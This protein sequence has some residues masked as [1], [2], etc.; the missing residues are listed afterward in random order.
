MPACAV[1]ILRVVFH[2]DEH[3]SICPAGLRENSILAASGGAHL[4]VVAEARGSPASPCVAIAAVQHGLVGEGAR[5]HHAV[6]RVLPCQVWQ[7]PHV[8]G[9]L[10]SPLVSLFN[11]A[12]MYDPWRVAAIQPSGE[13]VDQLAKVFVA[14]Q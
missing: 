10:L 2:L 7:H 11:L 4:G 14:Q 6:H 3:F 1:G 5:R 8:S 12:Q 13:K 9:R